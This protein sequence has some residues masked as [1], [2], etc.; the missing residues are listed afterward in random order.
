MKKI[1]KDVHEALSTLNVN[2]YEAFLVGGATRN[3]LL[4]L[5]I[6]DYDITTNAHP[7]ATKMLFNNYKQYNIGEKNGTI[8]VFLNKTKIDITTYRQDYEYKDY[9]HPE[10]VE[11]SLSLYEDVRRR[12]FTINSICMDKDGN[13]IDYFNGIN[14]LKHKTIKAIGDPNTRFREDA[15]RIL[16]AIRFSS[17]LNFKIEKNTKEALFNNSKLL[18]HIAN[19]R[20][21]E[22]LLKILSYGNSYKT[23]ITYKKIFE[24]FISFKKIDKKIDNFTNSYFA[25]AYALKNNETNNLKDIKFSKKEIVLINYLIDASKI[26]HQNDYDFICALSNAYEKYIL[27]FLTE[28]Y[29]IDIK[30]KYKRLKKY[31]ICENDLKINGDDLINLGYKGKEIKEIKAEL[32]DMIHKQMLVNTKSAILKY[33]NK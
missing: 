32:V 13:I 33:L 9:R 25:L 8:V 28:L 16:R 22:E 6:D 10:K 26:D 30:E 21:K 17:K 29:S 1:N 27:E 14:D 19:E 12:D 31:I 3:L 24:E 18:K 4:G 23:L 2:N 11:F 15:L 7:N 20:K 5:K